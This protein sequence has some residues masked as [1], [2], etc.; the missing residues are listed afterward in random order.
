[1]ETH[2]V[3]KIKDIQS[4]LMHE[5]S[6]G[7][8]YSLHGKSRGKVFIINNTFKDTKLERTGSDVDVKNLTDLFQ[9]LQFEVVT[10]TNLPA[11]KM[12]RFLEEERDN[13][14]T[15]TDIDCVVLILMSH[16]EG[17]YI[18][19][20]DEIPIKLTDIIEVFASN[21]CDGLKDK[22]RLVFV[23]ACR[24]VK[25]TDEELSKLSV[26]FKKQQ[27][28]PKTGDQRDSAP[29]QTENLTEVKHPS[30]DFLVV[31]ATPEGTLSYRNVHTGSWFLCAVVW[32]FKYHA[33]HEELQHLLIRV[34]RLVAK[35]KGSVEF[36]Q[37]LTISEVKSNLRKKFYFFPGVYGDPP[38]LFEK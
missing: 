28:Q 24:T 4:P 34:N 3:F 14:T 27:I 9:Q 20:N 1:M 12:V 8:V 15:W 16:G 33:K 13:I 5:Y 32:I 30:A 37:K 26:K 35:G 19:G 2:E 21:Y 36:G 25:R 17:P 29:Y 6:K 22:P 11:E 10:G 23:Q 7:D 18:Y 38:K 31:Y